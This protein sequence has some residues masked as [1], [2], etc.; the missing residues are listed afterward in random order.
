MDSGAWGGGMEGG[1]R[2]VRRELVQNKNA[3]CTALY[4]RKK[5]IRNFISMQTLKS[6]LKNLE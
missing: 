3:S 2:G 1:V 4:F 5:R 6:S